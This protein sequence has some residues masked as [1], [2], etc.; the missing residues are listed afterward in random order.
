MN[1][2]KIVV[3]DTNNLDNNIGAINDD[4][5]FVSLLEKEIEI[6]GHNISISG[7]NP[8]KLENKTM[9]K[10]FKI[11]SRNKFTKIVFLTPDIKD[12]KFLEYRKGKKEFFDIEA[13]RITSSLGTYSYKEESEDK[14]IQEIIKEINDFYLKGGKLFDEFDKKWHKNKMEK[15][16]FLNEEQ[17]KKFDSIKTGDKILNFK[18]N[19]IEKNK[20]IIREGSTYITY[21]RKEESIVF[22]SHVTTKTNKGREVSAKGFIDNMESFL[23]NIIET[24][25]F[26]F[27]WKR[28]LISI[29]G[30]S[31]LIFF[32]T[33]TVFNIF[34]PDGIRESM[35][36]IS[37]SF[38]SHWMY[39]IIWDMFMGYFLVYVVTLI[40]DKFSIKEA[41]TRFKERFIR[42][43][44]IAFANLLT[45][46][47]L[48]AS[49]VWS[50]VNYKRKG[51][52]MRVSSVIIEFGSMITIY[53]GVRTT[54][55]IVPMMIGTM[56]FVKY[57]SFDINPSAHY[58][59]AIA[60][61]WGGFGMVLLSL[62]IQ[63]FIFFSDRVVKNIVKV[64]QYIYLLIFVNREYFKWND[65]LNDFTSHYRKTALQKGLR[66]SKKTWAR[67]FT[68][69]GL[70]T[71][72]S[73]Y[74][75]I[76]SANIVL[77]SQGTTILNPFPLYGIKQIAYYIKELLPIPGGM[78]VVEA[79]T[80]LGYEGYLLS[81]NIQLTI[82][83]EEISTAITFTNR[84][85]TFYIPSG[86]TVIA[87]GGITLHAFFANN[88]N[89]R[90]HEL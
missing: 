69:V 5:L 34:D 74:E 80:K 35:D 10:I 19:K 26:N 16:I 83:V 28:K 56:E 68:M 11:A 6:F 71:I 55:A 58:A 21:K 31:A 78:G 59:T 2:S 13:L 24:K 29:I 90:S 23:K 82:P 46:S 41:N 73:A 79:V 86:I 30:F 18:I 72:L 4:L 57:M 77:E 52:S 38:T 84:L 20:L 61:A 87:G 49:A 70:S 1:K 47:F 50:F 76:Y 37:G 33:Y 89:H 48:I 51:D 64:Y 14:P 17:F 65:S 40:Y 88:K 12:I 27:N 54:I 63:Y 75:Q 36:A 42:L 39:L 45:G 7:T 15:E 81:N 32:T 3:I 22:T 60:L 9:R 25:K 8:K 62:M 67:I 66:K 43:Q 53:A 44:V 85:F